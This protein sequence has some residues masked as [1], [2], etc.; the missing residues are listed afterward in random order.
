[1]AYARQGKWAEA[2]EGFKSSE[3]A[4]AA[5]PIE[6][7]QLAMREAVRSSIEVHDFNG[8]AKLLNDFETLGVPSA[9][10]PS[11]D[12]LTGR[13]D[14][15]L[16]RTEDA[17]NAYR[18][19][20]ES[21]DRRNAAQGHLREI[22][23]RFSLGDIPRKDMIT[24]LETLTTVWRGDETEVE[25]LKLLAHLYTEDG[26]YR[27]AFHTMRTAMMAHPNSDMT[28][29][30]QDEAAVTFDSLFMAGKGDSLPPIEALGL[31]YDFRELTPIGRRGDEMIR[32]LVDRLV[33]V[34]LLD[35]AAELLQH[36][37]DHRLQGAARAQVATRLAVIYLMHH[38]P[39]LALATLQSTRTTDLS[40]ELRDQRLLLEARA[41]SDL[42]RHDLALEVI[43][44][45]NGR[46][47]IRL[48]S[49]ILWAAKRWRQAAE[50]I[51]LLYG[52]RWRDFTPLS[53]NER[54][55]ILRAA[56]GFSLAEEP[57]S[58]QR[59]RDK[60]AAKMTE[61]ADRRAFDIVSGPIG[62]SSSDFQN[63]AK[64]VASVDTLDAFLNDMRARYPDSA[65]LPPAPAPTPKPQASAPNT[66]APVEAAIAAAKKPNMSS[67]PLPPKAPQGVPL[68]PDPTPTGSIPR[69]P[70]ARPI[71]R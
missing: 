8:A 38:K 39:D 67:S 14:E 37:V 9:M 43:A 59:F 54:A 30:I 12:V 18:T 22:E 17:L 56:I 16:G 15:G 58:L 25:G 65:A 48:R 7:Q 32:K 66:V 40:N 29:K 6:L 62:T 34:D 49:D 64:T 11:I 10:E 26:R 63:V 60:Y 5:L 28:R 21:H 71:A 70:K 42:G 47:A 33:A 52:E 3:G 51:E 20:A 69:L 44:N 36:Q 13:L 35:Q 57:I 19:A 24:E 68:K 4:M 50:Q 31:F 53:V 27:N 61:D 2:R 23:L 41:L 46:E 1:M 55:D 45:L